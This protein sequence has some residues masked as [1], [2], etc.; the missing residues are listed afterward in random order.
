MEGKVYLDR[1]TQ[2]IRLPPKFIFNCKLKVGDI[3]GVS[4]KFIMCPKHKDAQIHTPMKLQK[5]GGY[6]YVV[7]IP[8][9][10]HTISKDDIVTMEIHL[11]HIEYFIK[12]AEEEKKNG[13]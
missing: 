7:N 1:A 2:R 3:L 10:Y 6:T 5:I 4:K 8:K 12:K 9:Q 13:T 11:H